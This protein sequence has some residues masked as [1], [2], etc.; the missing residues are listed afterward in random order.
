MRS[1]LLLLGL[2]GLLGLTFAVSAWADPI[3]SEN[4]R[5]W[6]Y[7]FVTLADVNETE[8][9]GTFA[10]ADP[11]SCG[12]V[13]HAAITPVYDMDFI[14]FTV[15][16][17]TLITF[18]TDAE[19][20]SPVGDTVIT[21]YNPSQVQVAT[22]DDEGPGLYSLLSYTTTVAGTYYGKIIGYSTRVG[23]Y[24]AFVNCV[25]PEPPPPNDTC[26]GAIDIPCGPFSLSGTTQWAMNDYAQASSNSCT[27]Y[28]SAGNDM[29]YK[30]TVQAGANI[31]VT[32]TTTA[33]GSFYIVT[34]CAVLDPCE[35]GADDTYT[36]QP[37]IIQ[38]TFSTAGTYYMILDSYGAGYGTWTL[39]GTLTCPTAAGNSTWGQV[40][41]LYR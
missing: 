17:G 35:I 1:K 22:S 6:S 11:I 20:A 29:V 23:T 10:T 14:S 37:E 34:D 32:Y 5:A 19:G 12:D 27:G 28:I 39:V 25:I 33:D 30:F 18:G 13:F 8:D 40:K 16:A 36:G 41:N 26:A 9:N 3:N 21:L 4:E 2:C 38:H 31:D 24:K 15:P 7:P